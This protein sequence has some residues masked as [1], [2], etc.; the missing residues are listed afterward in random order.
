M[1]Y[2]KKLDF[3]GK[4]H[5]YYQLYDILYDNIKKGIYKPGDKLPTENQLIQLY[6]VSRVTIRKAMDML[7]NEGLI[8]KRRGHGT[9]VQSKK[10]EQTLTKVLH[11]SNEMEKRGYK[12][13]VKMLINEK[14]YAN[15]K[16]A[17]ALSIPTGSP[18]IHVC[19]LRYANDEPM[20]IESAYLIYEKCPNVL[21]QDFSKISLRHFLQSEYNI[22]WKRAHQRIYAIK[23]NSR[24]AD[25]LNISDGD[26]L[27]YIERVSYTQNNEPGEYLQ[28]YYRGDRF[29]LTAELEA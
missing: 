27:I 16:I 25:Y 28:S 3:S 21:K 7:L 15:K 8:V 1:L 23:A 29:Y 22:F 9:F 13:T 24:F 26:P 18:L 20:C 4:T 17:E 11:F 19:R 10:V 14:V 12:S 6:G 2:L 5:L